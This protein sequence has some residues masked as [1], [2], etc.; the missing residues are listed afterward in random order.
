M[1]A[2]IVLRHQDSRRFIAWSTAL[3][4][5][6][7]LAGCASDGPATPE[8]PPVATVAITTHPT[9]IVVGASMPLI[10]QL[11]SADGEVLTDR[12]IAWTSENADIATVSENGTLTAR[13]AGVAR[14]VAASEGR[15]GRTNV[16]VIAPSPT[17]VIAAL[18]PN[19]VFAGVTT[20]VVLRVTGEGFVNGSQI[21]WDGAE[22][23]TEFVSASELRTTIGIAEL[24]QVSARAVTVRTPA[25][26][27]GASNALTFRID[28]APAPVPTIAGLVP[29]QIPVGWAQ[30]F[31]LTISGEG[32]T[33]RSRVLWDGASRETEFFSA[34]ALRIRVDP[35]DVRT[36]RDVSIVVET[37]APGGGRVQTIFP[38]RAPVVDRIDLLSPYGSSWTWVNNALP[39]SAVPRTAA[40]AEVPGRQATWTIDNAAI[41]TAV[42]TGTLSSAIYGLASGSTRVDVRV[43]NALVQRTISVYDAPLFD[44][45]YE[46]GSG[47]E[48]HIGLWSPTI[49]QAPRRLLIPLVAMNPSPSPTGAYI[50]F[51]G[52]PRGSGIN[53]NVDLYRVA[54]D[55]SDLQRLTG[56]LSVEYEPAWSPDGQRIAF[57]SNASGLNDVWVMNVDGSNLQQLTNARL[58]SPMPG[59][60]TSAGAPAWSPD[61]TR[62]AYVVTTNAS[63]IL[64][65]MNVDGSGKRALT[66]SG[67]G[68]AYDPTW[69]HDGRMIAFRHE[70][71]FPRQTTL[72]FVSAEDGATMFPTFLTAPMWTTPAFSPDGHWL[73]ASDGPM[74]DVAALYAV[75]LKVFGGPRIVL[76][77]TLGGARHAT[78]MRRP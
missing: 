13:T 64:W 58:Q 27:G 24:T 25:P 57:A 78:W 31:T 44:I 51:S 53:G 42:P 21:Y 37:D 48:R 68:N 15:T 39:F 4:I 23:A 19:T 10:A 72:Q 12:S 76:P 26:G 35:I 59:S 20:P 38:V 49:G 17:P 71:G 70:I 30:A 22:C 63:S 11:R 56:G 45:V 77:T 8:R 14:I 29:T 32:F 33:P 16:R 75:P 18:V 34:N 52:V 28:E 47:D 67:E 43:D 69:S 6:S 50:V 60:G 61:G 7:L 55:G 62:L 40:G 41:A 2:A 46:A 54:R 36:A 73:I 74:G 1:F 66:L 9:E 3:A 65:I 5:V